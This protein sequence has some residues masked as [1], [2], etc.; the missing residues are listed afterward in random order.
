[1]MTDNTAKAVRY[2]R[3]LTAQYLS[4]HPDLVGRQLTWQWGRTEQ[5]W[6]YQPAD[7]DVLP[8]VPL[9]KRGFGT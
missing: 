4:D 7:P 9:E 2:L 8:D 1:M 3:R 6:Q 5:G